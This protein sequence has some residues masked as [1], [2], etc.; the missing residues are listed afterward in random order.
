M[1]LSKNKIKFVK[2]LGQKKFRDQERLFLVEGPKIMEELLKS[3]RVESLK[4]VFV[5]DS[6]SLDL[7]E[8]IDIYSVSQPELDRI[9]SLKSA[10]QIIGVVSYFEVQELDLNESTMTLMLDKINDPGNLGTIIRTA[11]WFGHKQL[12]CSEGSVDMYNPKVVQSSM[13]AIFRLNVLYRNLTKVISDFHQ[14]DI[15]VYG[16]DMEGED[17]F[18]TGLPSKCGLVMGSE[19]HGISEEIQSEI[20][21]LTIPRFGETESLNVA[22]AAGILSAL[23]RKSN[24]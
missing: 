4:E 13:G 14:A 11:D 10:N 3:E 15:E 1:Q 20:K 22:M 8:N 6:C 2:S 24:N 7:P 18:N 16:A 17:A 23:Q 5:T 19:S 12:I 21:R 9:S